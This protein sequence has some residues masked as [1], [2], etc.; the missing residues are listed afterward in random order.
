VRLLIVE[1]N[2]MNGQ[3]LARRLARRGFAV[4]IATDGRQAIAEAQRLRPA[5]ILMDLR[6]PVLDGWEA[7]R[8]L[9][10]GPETEAIPIVAL[11]AHA[12]AEDRQRALD[13]GCDDYETKPIDL[14]RLLDKIDRLLKGTHRAGHER[15]AARGR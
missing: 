4:S 7:A 1:D 5:L 6:L 14:P 2:E 11:T 13:A 3:M 8:Q 12:L 9:K 10:A 15:H